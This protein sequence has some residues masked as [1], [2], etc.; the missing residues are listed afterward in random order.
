[1]RVK[2]ENHFKNY[3][4]LNF[5]LIR[6][7]LF[8]LSLLRRPCKLLKANSHCMKFKLFGI[9]QLLVL[10]T[11]STVAQVTNPAPYCVYDFSSS[12]PAVTGGITNVSFGTINNTTVPGTITSLY[13]YYNNIAAPSFTVG[14]SY[15]MNIT[16]N[17]C[18]DGEPMYGAVYIDYNGDNVFQTTEKIWDQ[19]VNPLPVSNSGGASITIPIFVTIPASAT[20]GTT[21]MRIVRF[22]DNVP[23]SG[24]ANF[25]SNYVVPPCNTGTG[26][27]SHKGEVEDYDII[28][29]AG[30][31]QPTVI[32][33]AA[34]GVTM[35]DA[36]LNG[37]V[38]MNNLGTGTISFDYGTATTYGNSTAA[39][40]VTV[41]GNVLVPVSAALT[42]LNPGTLYHYRAVVTDATGNVFYGSDQ[43]FV[44]ISLP[45]PIIN[46][47]NTVGI[48]VNSGTMRG[49]ANM[50][51]VAGFGTLEFEYGLTNAYGS[52]L[53]ATPASV[54]GTSTTVFSANATGLTPNTTYHY[55]AKL[56]ENGNIHYGLDSTFTTLPLPDPTIITLAAANVTE[57]TAIVNGAA[58]AKNL[59]IGIIGF[60]YG[61]TTA[62]GTI[63]GATP[64]TISGS[65]LTTFD[66]NLSGLNPSTTYHY[67]SFIT[68]NN[69]THY[70]NDFTFTTRDQTLPNISTTSATNISTVGVQLNGFINPQNFGS[71]VLNFEWGPT[72]ALGNTVAATPNV[73]S[74]NQLVAVN[75]YLQSN[76]SYNT[77]YYFRLIGNIAGSFYSG[78]ILSFKVPPPTA[79]SF[80]DD[81]LGVY[82]NPIEDHVTI[83]LKENITGI[84]ILD[85][86]GRQLKK[87]EG[88]NSPKQI[89]DNLGLDGGVYILKVKTDKNTYT[90]KISI[91]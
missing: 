73:V 35:T 8:L 86:L 27:F 40:P 21:R 43:T 4:A 33:N 74:G 11:L 31:V 2:H 7:N 52:N 79:V 45:T 54:N 9:I 39:V 30:A 88:N 1:M 60:E 5:L 67:R 89:I 15:T 44:T 59:G 84:V 34:T 51:G 82:P 75:T 14:N 25:I 71:C 80:L 58:N 10:V 76:F 12:T 63:V 72:P 18:L 83:E 47:L 16:F 22:E 19:G 87:Y 64:S 28:I 20:P 77:T 26:T 29:V 78:T 46:T 6:K 69:Q 68:I 57:N 3:L 65:T 41:T 50:N 48:T 53:L 49:N 90:Q 13:T 66:V 55:R 23:N 42:A 32:T 38:N 91:K 81:G 62:Y 61:L 17:S 85:L 36:T 24:T 70:G 37:D 56:T